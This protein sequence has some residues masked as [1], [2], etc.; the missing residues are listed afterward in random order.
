MGVCIGK[1]VPLRSSREMNIIADIVMA[2]WIPAVL[3]LFAAFPPQR[4]AIIAFVVGW[5]FL[6]FHSYSLPLFPDFTKMSATIC[7]ILLGAIIFDFNRLVS[8]RF[9]WLDLP[10]AVFCAAPFFSSISN[11]LGVY[12]GVS[13]VIEQT[14]AWGLPYLIGRLYIADKEGTR[15]LA[16]AIFVGG[17][18]YIPFCFFEMR[19]S[20][21]LHSMVYGMIHRPSGS[22][23]LRLGGYRPSVFLDSGLQLGMWMTVASLV[24]YWLW[25]TK[26][27]TQLLGVAMT[28]LAPFLMATTIMCRSTGAL[29]LLFAGIA[30]LEF[31]RATKTSIAL[32]CLLLVAPLYMVTRITDTWDG[33]GVTALAAK[34]DQDRA[35]SFQFRL[36]NEDL[37]IDKALQQPVFGWGAWGRNR[38]VDDWGRATTITDGRWIIELG[39]HGLVGMLSLYCA[40]LLP[41]VVLLVR[42]PSAKLLSAEMAPP[43]ALGVIVILYAIDSVPNGM[44]NPMFALAAGAVAGCV[45]SGR[46]FDA[47]AEG[48][49]PSRDSS[50]K[51]RKVRVPSRRLTPGSIA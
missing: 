24:G 17:L 18:I 42:V 5:L 13:G 45:T 36:D 7:G 39:Q 23:S 21:Q 27:L 49:P 2:A 47:S 34:L 3:L 26:A 43:L 1:I 48:A 19:M 37:L 11:G 41:L 30:A 9:R 12:D 16:I 33:S 50:E 22:F 25:R 51:P 44:V 38:V 15:Q 31:S 6:P 29:L 32:W 20:P 46:K 28:W 40:M 35:H 4:A 8:V 10:V 14:V